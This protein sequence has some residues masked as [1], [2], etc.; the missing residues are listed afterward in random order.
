MRLLGFERV[1]LDPGESRQITISAD[2]RLLA[3][4][5][6][7]A[8]RWHI[9]AGQYRVALAS[10]ADALDATAEASVDE[11]MFGT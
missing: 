2:P 11:R 4:Y 10:A 9:M 1:E 6:G 5:D 3:R 8:A 7:G